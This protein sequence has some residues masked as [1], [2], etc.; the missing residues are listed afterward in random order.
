MFHTIPQN[1]VTGEFLKK[2]VFV[3][4]LLGTLVNSTVHVAVLRVS[5]EIQG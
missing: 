1:H 5:F 4:I 2:L 3:L